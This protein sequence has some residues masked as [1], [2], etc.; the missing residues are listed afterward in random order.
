MSIDDSLPLRRVLKLATDT[1]AEIAA[2]TPEAL[3]ERVRVLELDIRNIGAVAAKYDTGE[4]E[5]AA[6]DW[7]YVMGVCERSLKGDL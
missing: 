7:E 4:R 2:D 1:M 5:Y 3:R 6:S